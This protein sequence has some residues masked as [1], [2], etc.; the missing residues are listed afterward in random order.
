MSRR[1]PTLRDVAKHA[2][3]AESTVS[4]VINNPEMVTPETRKRVRLA[5][6]VVGYQVSTRGLIGLVIPD[7]RNPFFVDLGLLFQ[8]ALEGCGLQTLVLSSDG[9][10]QREAGLI[11]HCVSLGLSGIIYVPVGR[12]GQDVLD[13]L[14]SSDMPVVIFDRP[15]ELA[16][17]DSV[18]IDNSDGIVRALDYLVAHG[19]RKI[20]HVRGPLDTVSG[21]ERFAGFVAG[22]DLN[23]V[24]LR[25]EWIW[26]GDFTA[27]AGWRCG[28]QLMD[29]AD[30]PTAVVCANDLMAIG[31]L[32]AVQQR[33]WRVPTDLSVIGF[34][35]IEASRWSFPA[36]TTV[37][38]Q[39]RRLVDAAAELMTAR[40]GA[41]RTDDVPVTLT[42]QARLVPRASVARHNTDSKD[43]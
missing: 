3:C 40:V 2:Y 12:P 24:A 27:A 5:I 39:T 29:S 20:G 23:G 26:D 42:V 35:D 37:S 6:K 41:P 18:A 9:E 8:D 38:Q 17:H 43:R 32:Q 13:A 22:L 28:A 30:R 15:I 25:D 31:L 11:R 14:R 16:E 21:M 4:R 34:D 36:L 19:H 10:A 1:R 33:G 7:R